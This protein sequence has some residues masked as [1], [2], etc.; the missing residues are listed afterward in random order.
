MSEWSERMKLNLHNRI[1]KGTI[2]VDAGGERVLLKKGRF[3]KYRIIVPPVIETDGKLKFIWIN[4]LFNGW[5]NLVKLIGILVIAG[6]VY[7]SVH[8]LFVQ[9]AKLAGNLCYTSCFSHLN[10]TG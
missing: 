5:G 7:S 9:Y 6:L 8:N 1:K 10:V 2:E 4:F 3:G